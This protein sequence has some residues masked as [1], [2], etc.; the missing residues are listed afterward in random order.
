M[1]VLALLAVVAGLAGFSAWITWRVE[2]SLPPRGQFVAVGGDRIHYVTRG[3]GSPI[4]FVHG[5]NGQLDNFS[6]LDMDALAAKHR[7]VVLDRPG[8]GY[9]TRGPASRATLSAQ[10]V[11]VAAFIRALG[12]DKPVVVGHSLGGAVALALAL[13][14]PELISGAALIAP[15]SHHQDEA[16][17]PLRRLAIRSALI[18]WLVAHTVAVPLTVR[19]GE[20]ISRIVF[21]PDDA[22]LDFPEK[23]GGLLALRSS[24]FYGASTDLAAAQEDLAG[25][26]ARYPELAVP[27][28]VIFGRQDPILDAT[29]HGEALAAKSPRVALTLVDGGHMLPVTMPGRITRWLLHHADAVATDGVSRATR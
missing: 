12:L 15:L 8:S 7:V 2:R 5:L 16:P 14:H 19:H 27:V 1:L 13:N 21:G 20:T 29:A 4:V 3:E 9:S 22:P 24:S 10:A 11:T 23:G 17:P 6:Y 26:E 28:A 18:R 25:M